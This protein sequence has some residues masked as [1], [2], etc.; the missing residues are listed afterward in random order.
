MNRNVFL[1]FVL[2]VDK[3]RIAPERIVYLSQGKR[4]RTNFLEAAY[5]EEGDSALRSPGAAPTPPGFHFVPVYNSQ[6]RNQPLMTI[7][8]AREKS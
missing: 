7:V 8:L 1:M 5:H 4:S 2:L 3:A 6:S